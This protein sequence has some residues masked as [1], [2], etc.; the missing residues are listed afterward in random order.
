M[1][2]EEEKEE[3]DDNND[4]QHDGDG[5]DAKLFLLCSGHRNWESWERSSCLVSNSVKRLQKHTTCFCNCYKNEVVFLREPSN[6]SKES[7]RSS[8]T[9]KVTQITGGCQ[10]PEIQQHLQKLGGQETVEWPWN[11]WSINCT[12]TGRQLARL[13]MVTSHRRRRAWSFLRT[14]SRMS[15]YSTE[16]RLIKT[17]PMLPGGDQPS[18]S[19]VLGAADISV[20]SWVI[21][22][23]KT[24]D[25]GTS[26][27]SSGK[28][29]PN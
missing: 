22:A 17:L 4:D 23:L 11:W 20:L 19:P 24:E 15:K 28:W 13:F 8:K 25:V 3:D 2:K 1:K 18:V 27:T 29:T 10:P 7:D 5:N 26:R 14:A 21:T 9:L 6:G 16:L 12:L